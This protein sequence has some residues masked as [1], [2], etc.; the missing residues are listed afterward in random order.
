MLFFV[1]FV[2]FVNFLFMN[3]SMIN[4]WIYVILSSLSILSS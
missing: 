1:K 4:G 2:N 3:L